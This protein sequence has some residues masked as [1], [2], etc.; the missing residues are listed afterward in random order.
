MPTEDEVKAAL[1]LYRSINTYGVSNGFNSTMIKAG[2]MKVEMTVLDIHLSAPDTCHGGA[3][4][5]LMDSVL[6]GA[7]LSL[8]FMDGMIVSTIEFK[9]NYLA[10]AFKGD[11]LLGHA[12]IDFHGKSTI[13]ASG[14][15]TNQKN[16]KIIAKAMGTFNKYP[17][18]KRNFSRV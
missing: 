14:I 11:V 10:P 12:T 17:I 16:G 3:I 7:A 1:D 5:G 15:I 9:I 6:G 13:V 8:A 18:G 2:E 4:A